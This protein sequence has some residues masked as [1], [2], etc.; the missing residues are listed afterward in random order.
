MT[1]TG[2]E[3]SNFLLCQSQSLSSICTLNSYS[4][5]SLHERKA[6]SLFVKGRFQN[7]CTSL[8]FTCTWPECGHMTTHCWKGGWKCSLWTGSNVPMA[9]SGGSSLNV[10]A[11]FSYSPL[12]LHRTFRSLIILGTKLPS[13]YH[14]MCFGKRVQDACH[15]FISH[16]W[17]TPYISVITCP[18]LSVLPY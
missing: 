8:C 10:Y 16:Q 14:F 11:Q 9:K 2:N 13:R 1:E 17:Q 7:F 4:S 12:A 15:F 6:L 18:F 3:T 5:S